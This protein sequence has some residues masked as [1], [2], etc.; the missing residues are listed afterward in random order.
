M[1]ENKQELID[2]IAKERMDRIL[3]HLISK[4]NYDVTYDTKIKQ[5]PNDVD[6]FTCNIT[7]SEKFS[8]SNESNFAYWKANRE[9]KFYLRLKGEITDNFIFFREDRASTLGVGDPKWDKE[10]RK[11][12]VYDED[13][14]LLLEQDT[15]KEKTLSL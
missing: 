15:V 12:L 5:N 9:L 13:G 8:T 10:Y 3:R 14:E 11:F 7:A 6:S 2:K 4:D 1:V